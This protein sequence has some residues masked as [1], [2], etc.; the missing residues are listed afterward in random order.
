M[1]KYYYNKNYFKEINT[2]EKAYWLGFL[3]ADGCITRYYKNE[4]LSTMGLELT[5]Q[6]ADKEHLEKF[7]QALES[8]V[9]LSKKI[10]KDKYMSY[11]I[12]ICCKSLCEDLINLGCV[13]QKSL[14]LKF[15]NN[16]I[17]PD[18]FIS[19]FIRGYFDGDGGIHYGETKVFNKQKQ[20]T[21]LQYNYSC[22]FA[23]TEDFLIRLK[24]VLQDNGVKVSRI[25]KDKRSNCRT[26]YIYGKENID[27]FKQYIYKDSNVCLSRK[28][29]KFFYVQNNNELKINQR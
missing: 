25:Y 7:K 5:L 21:Y 13:P 15:P 4:K 24:E 3:Y 2:P 9:P 20:N 23:G 14:I 6:E 12:V 10:I 27:V 28:L 8:N 1:S 11:R 22:Y 16:I 18:N 17:V 26:I 19:H 29:D